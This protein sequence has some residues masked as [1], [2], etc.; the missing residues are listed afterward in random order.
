MLCWPVPVTARSK[1]SVCGRSPSKIVGSNPTGSWM[2][3]CCEC[4][5]LSGRGL[6]DELITRPE[7]SYRLWCVV[8]WDLETSWMRKPWPIGGCRTKNNIYIYIYMCVCVC[9]CVKIYW[10][11]GRNVCRY[12]TVA[13]SWRPQQIFEARRSLK[14]LH[15]CKRKSNS[16]YDVTSCLIG[17]IKRRQSAAP[18]ICTV[19]TPIGSLPNIYKCARREK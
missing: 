11:F 8:W 7:E 18:I 14:K 17:L 16:V 19:S 9:V 2:F 5:V 3:I 12:S 13:P 4:C 6:C 1:V 15:F 10:K